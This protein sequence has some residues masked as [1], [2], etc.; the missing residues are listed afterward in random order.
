M[1]GDDGGPMNYYVV[2]SKDR[3]VA[4]VTNFQ[5]NAYLWDLD[6]GKKRA[7]LDGGKD[8]AWLAVFSPDGKTLATRGMTEGVPLWDAETGKSTSRIGVESNGLGYF[9]FSPDGKTLVAERYVTPGG[10]TIEMSLWDVARNKQIRQW[11]LPAWGPSGLLFSPNGRTVAL[12]GFS[13]GVSLWEATTG[14]KLF[15]LPVPKD[16]PKIGWLDCPVF[17]PDGQMLAAGGATGGIY[18]WEVRTAKVRA[19]LLGHHDRVRSLDFSPDGARLISG[20]NDTTALIWDLT[21]LAGAAKP[22]KAL[23]PTNLLSLWDDLAD[24]DAGKAYR[25]SWRLASD[26]EASIAFLRKRLRPA[27]VDADVIAKALAALDSDDFDEREAASRRLAK[28]GDLAGPALRTTLEG[29]PS[30]EARRRMEELLH[31]L[32]GPVEAP[33]QARALRGVEVLERVGSAEARRLLDEL[34]KG[35]PGSALTRDARRRWRLANVPSDR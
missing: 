21:G 6:S 20:S 11:S 34:A 9:A 33:E 2:F 29:K 26:P 3:K 7:E 8:K 23:A 15:S 16:A 14:R 5:K 12:G 31:R 24:A 18:L 28:L 27:E 4:A 19:V 35:A 30:D 22:A 32:D 17:S 1:K 13:S 10:Q 25:A